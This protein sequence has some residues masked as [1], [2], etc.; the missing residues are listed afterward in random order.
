[1]IRH[2]K[3]QE[4]NIYLSGG[5][6][7]AQD[8]GAG[9]RQEVSSALQD[10]GFFPLDITALDRSYTA[11][12]GKLYSHSG[13]ENFIKRKANIRKH[14]VYTD[15]ELIKNDSDAVIL[16]YDESVRLGAGTISE[17]QVAFLHDIPVFI[18]SRWKRWW[19]EVPG[20]LQAVS[21]KIFI[22]FDDCIEYFASLPSGILKRDIYGN[23][24]GVGD[25]Y[26]CSLT[27]E[28]F[29]KGHHHFVSRI[30]PLYSSESV[31]IVK[32]IHEDKKDRYEFFL[33]CLERQATEENEEEN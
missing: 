19:D 23:H 9:W 6:E 27:G 11:K 10:V 4:G 21:T 17:A 32:E 15:I 26:L 16:Y 30:S 18:V 13:E 33:E 2:P 20:W 12:H 1:M 14:F 24:R 7:H 28:P 5:M 25:Y 22:S 31:R 29:K 3:Y 8:E